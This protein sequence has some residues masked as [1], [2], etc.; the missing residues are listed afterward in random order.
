MPSRTEHIRITAARVTVMN[1]FWNRDSRFG[2]KKRGTSRLSPSFSQALKNTRVQTLNSPCTIAG[3]Y[4][5]AGT[6]GAGGAALANYGEIEAVTSENY[7]T[8]LNQF[9]SWLA[10]KGPGGVLLTG[11]AIR[12]A[13]GAGTQFCSSF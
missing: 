10:R 12:A 1:T 4:V 5:A 2:R 11:A 13:Y 6:L 9:F 7:P 3:F 8:W